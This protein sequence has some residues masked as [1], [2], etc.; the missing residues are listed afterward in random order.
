MTHGDHVR[1]AESMTAIDQMEV[2]CRQSRQPRLR[3]TQVVRR[4]QRDWSD[5]SVSVTVK[6]ELRE[7][8]QI[9]EYLQTYWQTGFKALSFL[10]KTNHGFRQVR[11]NFIESTLLTTP[12]A[13]WTPLTREEYI[14][15]VSAITRPFGDEDLNLRQMTIVDDDELAL[16]ADCVGGSCPRR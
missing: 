8:P 6:Y 1:T 7:L 4:L 13:P 10:L 11:C 16:E 2:R 14:E 12:Q 3:V 5:N 9:R 15:R